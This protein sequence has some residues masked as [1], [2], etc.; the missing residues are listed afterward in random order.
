MLPELDIRTP[1]AL[2]AAAVELRPL[3][4]EDWEAV[5]EIYWTGMRNGLAT[6]ET[7]PPTWEE[8]DARYRPDQ[9]LV[10]EVPAGVVGFA[11]LAP[12]SRRRVY[13]GVVEASVFIA[14]S[15]RGK[16][17]GRRLIE[18]LIES[19]ERARIWTIQASIFPEN[20]AS[21]ALFQR[22]GFRV[23]GVRERIGKRDGLWRDTVLLERRSPIVEDV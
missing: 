20:R 11:A 6:L 22:C 16:G 9:R 3:V 18:A 4:A 23:V 12:V 10:A 14:E 2:Q 17:I 13:R 21:L 1:E 15:W 7:E 8:W 5:E 19:S